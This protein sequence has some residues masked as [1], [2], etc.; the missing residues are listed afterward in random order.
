[1]G[2]AIIENRVS[3]DDDAIRD[4]L[5]CFRSDSY[6]GYTYYT[7]IF[8]LKKRSVS[9]YLAQD[10]GSRITID[11][12][13]ELAKS[14]HYYMLKDLFPGGEKILNDMEASVRFQRQL[15]TASRLIGI[16]SVIILLRG[17]VVSSRKTW[18]IDC[19]MNWKIR[20]LFFLIIGMFYWSFIVLTVVQLFPALVLTN[21]LE[22]IIETSVVPKAIQYIALFWGS[23]VILGGF[24]LTRKKLHQFKFNHI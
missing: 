5:E 23:G 19:S 22:K 8:D 12:D 11:L 7:S 10:F 21:L 16:G 14:D 20:S 3:F 18:N 13:E 4:T 2:V 24:K 9:F 6:E 15:F 1:M 17:L